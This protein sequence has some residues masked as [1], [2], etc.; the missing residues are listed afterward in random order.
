MIKENNKKCVVIGAGVSGIAAA[1]RMRNKGYSVDVYETNS[2]AG[3][4]LSA[5]SSKGYRFDMGPS[6][7]TMPAYV[8]ELF[9]LS[10]KDPREFF[11]YVL[12]NPVY[13]YF[14]EDGTVLDAFHDKEQFAAEMANNT[15]DEKARILRYLDKTEVIYNLTAGVFLHNSL[16]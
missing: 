2:F 15:L 7:F 4:K 3:G 13:H 8:D 6:V 1:I 11:N 10:G 5:E 14:F 12:L 9:E 16:H